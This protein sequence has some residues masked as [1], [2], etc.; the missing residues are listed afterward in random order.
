MSK[1]RVSWL[2]EKGGVAIDEYAQKLEGY[3]EA[4]ADGRVSADEVA[5]QEQRVVDLMKEVEPMLDDETHAKVSELLL[6]LTA[7][8]I[9]QTLHTIHE[10]RPVSRFRG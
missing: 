2:D 3:V 1:E 9:M 6:Q 4:L 7:F 5:A 8:D 10:A